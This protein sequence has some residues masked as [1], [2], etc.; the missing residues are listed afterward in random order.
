MRIFETQAVEG[1]RRAYMAVNPDA[2]EA[3]WERWNG[4]TE[5][6]VDGD[7]MRATVCDLC[8]DS[9]EPD[10]TREEIRQISNAS[11]YFKAAAEIVDELARDEGIVLLG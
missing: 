11:G 6:S 1:V 9:L 3:S 10:L 4:L 7:N 5:S 2:D 8:L